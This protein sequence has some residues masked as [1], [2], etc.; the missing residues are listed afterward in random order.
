MA[1]FIGGIAAIIPKRIQMLTQIGFKALIA[2]TLACL[3]TACIAG[4]FA[5]NSSILLGR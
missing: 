4:I 1:I 3:M 2:A 5:S